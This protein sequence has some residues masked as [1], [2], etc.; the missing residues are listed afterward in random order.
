MHM[1]EFHSQ[2][3]QESGVYQKTH[4]GVSFPDLDDV[5]TVYSQAGYLYTILVTKFIFTCNNCSHHVI[6]VPLCIAAR[7]SSPAIHRYLPFLER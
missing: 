5:L 7:I 1:P 2:N 4:H 6:V 3:G